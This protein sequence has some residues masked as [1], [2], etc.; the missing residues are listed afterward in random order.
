M[1][2]MIDGHNLIASLPNIDLE[3]PDDEACLVRL[4][5]AFYT[6]ARKK[7]TVYFDRRAPGLMDPPT[8]GGVQVHFVASDRT[9]DEAIRAHLNHLGPQAQN[10]TVVS[11][12]REVRRAAH[13]VGARVL[14]SD[15]FGKVLLEENPPEKT[16]EKPRHEMSQEE[17]EYWI[18]RFEKG[19]D[20][21]V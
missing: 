16:M 13:R 18:Q 9:A 19:N 14:S 5:R 20:E 8:L 11:S 10:W 7:I 21:G 6:R 17:L 15:A 3:D 2:Y 1:P 4:L 12:D